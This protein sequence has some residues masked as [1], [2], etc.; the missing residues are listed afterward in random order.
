MKKRGVAV[1][2]SAM[3]IMAISFAACRNVPGGR[4][5]A[6]F[7]GDI[8][9]D[10]LIVGT[11]ISG[12]VAALSALDAGARNV[13]II[14]KMAVPGGSTRISGG[15]FTGLH[16]SNEALPPGN[17]N[18]E[19]IAAHGEANFRAHWARHTLVDANFPFPDYDRV[20]STFRQAREA[21][22]WLNDNGVPFAAYREQV[23]NN[24]PRLLG[25]LA[26]G[27]GPGFVE[28]YMAEIERRG[29]TIL[30]EHE[31]TRI[32]MS[33][34]R[35]VGI[36]ARHRGRTITIAA[37][38][39]ILATG[40]FTENPAL[41]AQWTNAY[42]RS[43]G[44]KRASTFACE[45][46]TG[47]GILIAI[48]DAG[49]DIF[50]HPNGQP[51]VWAVISGI[52]SPAP[53]ESFITPEG[54]VSLADTRRNVNFALGGTRPT[55]TGTEAGM[56]L[57]G[58]NDQI[59]VNQ[60]GARFVNEDQ[61]F[62]SGAF[63]N[64]F[65]AIAREEGPCWIIYSADTTNAAMR[66]TLDAMANVT[67]QSVVFRRN[68]IE[69][70]GAAIGAPGL[71]AA[72]AAYNIA[73]VDAFGKASN[74]RVPL[75]NGPFF[76]VQVRCHNI[77]GSMGGLV[78]D[79]FGRVYRSNQMIPANIIPNLYAVGEISNRPFF[80]QGYV[81]GSC[82]SLFAVIGRNVGRFVAESQR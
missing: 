72:V 8:N 7:I 44:L 12:G 33:G 28:N 9:T 45:S 34:P 38:D 39:V 49:A 30:L 58:L 69:E 63:N 14:D 76:A 25:R 57:F 43:L 21:L 62:G 61:P 16:A 53:F 75:Q 23:G 80:G 5:D 36:E 56:P 82:L 10:I 55:G 35:V 6:A 65:N 68:S 2:L 42:D 64:V 22:R 27:G 15:N 73:P 66:V 18:P 50:R 4:Q 1:L 37:R 48:R 70:L 52:S 77:I 67:G 11:G 74:R 79:E 54:G 40:G 31:M 19:V 20:V 29:A 51:S 17:W 47:E 3:L 46:N 41:W 71:A 26:E 24:N 32:I 13:V 81:G 78:T 59:I 60:T